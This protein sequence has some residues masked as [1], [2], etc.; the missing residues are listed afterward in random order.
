MP[1]TVSSS[2]LSEMMHACSPLSA[3]SSFINL[4]SG[5]I[6]SLIC[7]ASFVLTYLHGE[8][9]LR[10]WLCLAHVIVVVKV[11]NTGKHRRIKS[12][13]KKLGSN[14]AYLDECRISCLV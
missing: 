7:P 11:L 2:Q 3:A 12:K 13:V 14:P 8:T 1:E 4:I 10:G 9:I 6:L 5:I